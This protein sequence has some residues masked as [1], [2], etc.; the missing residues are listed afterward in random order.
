VTLPY[1]DFSIEGQE[2]FAKGEKPSYMLQVTPVFSDTWFGSVDAEHHIADSRWAHVSM[3]KQP[4][5]QSGVRNSYGYI[6]SYWNN[7]PDPGEEC[8]TFF[9]SFFLFFCFALFR[10]LV[11]F[12]LLF[13]S[14]VL[15]FSLLFLPFTIASTSL[16]LSLSLFLL[17]S[18]P[19]SLSLLLCRPLSLSLTTFILISFHFI[20]FYTLHRSPPLSLQF[21]RPFLPPS[22]FLLFFSHLFSSLLIFSPLPPPPLHFSLFSSSA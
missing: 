7:N 5:M 14:F 18:R 2:V 22:S 1:W 20:F 3:P 13:F 8:W 9:F 6:R 19:L 11:P 12:F 21:S 10:S 15:F 4:D 16:S 17:L